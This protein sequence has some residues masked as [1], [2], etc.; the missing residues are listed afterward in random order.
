MNAYGCGSHCHSMVEM[1]R[2]AFIIF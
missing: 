1:L 2:I